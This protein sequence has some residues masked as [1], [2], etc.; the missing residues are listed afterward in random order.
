MSD[1]GKGVD[2]TENDGLYT[3]M[4]VLKTE[5]K[6]WVTVR[7][8][9]TSAASLAY[10]RD[11]GFV[12]DA[13]KATVQIVRPRPGQSRLDASARKG[14]QYS[15][16]VALRGPTGQYEVVVT[17]SA[18]NGRLARGNAL[19]EIGTDGNVRSIVNI[20]AA[21]LRNLQT[22]GPYTLTSIEAYEIGTSDRLLRGRWQGAD[23][24]PAHKFKNIGPP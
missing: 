24:T 11:A 7:A 16:P 18:N 2:T 19:L 20:G 10:E 23:K 6:Y 8:Q 21:A 3:G 13:T 12:L 9:G 5:G 17:L 15:I 4:L 14:G 22:P 1:N